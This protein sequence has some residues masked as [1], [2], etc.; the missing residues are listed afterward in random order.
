MAAVT[1]EWLDQLKQASWRDVPFMVDSIDVTAGDNVVVR[2]YPFQDQPAVFRMGRGMEEIK[3]SAYVIGNNYTAYRDELRESL[4]DVPPEGGVLIH[5]TEGA[6]RCF[7]SAKYHVKENPTAEGGMARFDLTFVRAQAKQYPTGEANKGVAAKDAADRLAAIAKA[8]FEAQFDNNG[9][10]SAGQD[11]ISKRATSLIDLSWA[12]TGVQGLRDALDASGAARAFATLKLTLNELVNTPRALASEVAS[13]F[14]EPINWL[15]SAAYSLR[16]GDINLLGAGQEFEIVGKRAQA[17]MDALKPVMNVGA[18]LPAPTLLTQS[19]IEGTTIGG[20]SMLSM[21][22]FGR[23]EA[24]P[25]S[26]SQARADALVAQLDGLVEVL[27]TAQAVR[28]AVEL[29]LANIDQAFEIRDLLDQ[30]FN[31]LIERASSAA[32]PAMPPAGNAQSLSL[33]DALRAAHGA[34]L[35]DL[36]ARSVDLSRLTSYTPATWQ[37]VIYISYR[38]FGTVAYADEIMAMNPHIRHPLLVPPNKPLR[39]IRHD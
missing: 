19:I 21:A 30:Q 28:A 10:S 11:A 16:A 7:V 1:I 23:G 35:A 24:I 3:L 29:P 13:M 15:D 31:R 26:P 37:P 27:A 34:V 14:A 6:I 5:P 22:M 8:D 25:T 2:E 20:G 4:H 12:R 18:S 33:F 9:V 17:W 38:L 39:I 36:Q 32:A